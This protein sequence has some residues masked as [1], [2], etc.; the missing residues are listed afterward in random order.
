MPVCPRCR[1][2]YVAGIGRCR[3]CEV[4]L[5]EALPVPQPQA[6]SDERL[7]LIELANFGTVSEAEMIQELLSNNSIETVLRG[8]TDS[9]SSPA[10]AEPVTLL[11]QR[12][13][14]D[15]ARELYDAFFAGEVDDAEIGSPDPE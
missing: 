3:D 1:T 6:A 11:V 7:D 13:D 10:H 8:E 9:I 14:L 12:K 5:V 2:E 15:A 4:E